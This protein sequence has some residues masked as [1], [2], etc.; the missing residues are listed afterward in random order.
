MKRC[1]PLACAR[2]KSIELRAVILH[3]AL[4]DAYWESAMKR[5]FNVE[6]ISQ[7]A[8]QVADMLKEAIDDAKPHLRYQTSDYVRSEAAKKLVD[9]TGDAQVEEALEMLKSA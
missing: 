5:M 6:G 3:R 7:T 8:E 1:M 4:R 2:L 9:P